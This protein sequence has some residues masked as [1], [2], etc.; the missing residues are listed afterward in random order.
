[1]Q[2]FRKGTMENRMVELAI[3][4][5]ERQKAELE[6]EIDRVKSGGALNDRSGRTANGKTRPNRSQSERMKAHWA[7]RRAERSIASRAEATRKPGPQSAAAKKAVSERMKAYWAKQK[8]Q[9]AKPASQNK[10]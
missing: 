6:A 9:K 7:R 2:D 5:L 3:E 10:A 8:Q 1:M 4:A